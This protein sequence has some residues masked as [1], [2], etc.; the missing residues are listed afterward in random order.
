V[1]VINYAGG[2]EGGGGR[3]RKGEG[4]LADSRKSCYGF[5]PSRFTTVLL[6]RDLKGQ[7]AR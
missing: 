1:E 4:K 5:S 6:H 3:A 7:L 2:E